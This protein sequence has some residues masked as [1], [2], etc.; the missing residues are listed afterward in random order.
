MLDFNIQKKPKPKKINLSLNKKTNKTNKNQTN[1]P[2]AN[3]YTA[4]K[5]L[6]FFGFFFSRASLKSRAALS[7]PSNS[8]IL[9]R[10]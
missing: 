9:S 8:L 10:P 1:K 3:A 5:E 7:I 6:S 2:E 4:D